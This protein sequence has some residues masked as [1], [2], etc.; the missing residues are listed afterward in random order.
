VFEI[1]ARGNG[2]RVTDYGL[3]SEPVYLLPGKTRVTFACPKAKVY[4]Y[5]NEA[6]VYTP[7]PGSYYLRCNSEGKLNVARRYGAQLFNQADR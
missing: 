4:T 6:V 7:R 2:L 3:V 5:D 1:S